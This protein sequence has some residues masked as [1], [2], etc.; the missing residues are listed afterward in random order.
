MKVFW[1]GVL[2]VFTFYSY[3]TYLEYQRRVKH[4]VE[5][6]SPS[7]YS[8]LNKDL[9]TVTIKPEG[10]SKLVNDSLS[11]INN[12]KYSYI[13]ETFSIDS[14]E[15]L[16]NQ[17]LSCIPESFGYSVERGKEV[18]QEYWYPKC[19]EKTKQQGTY[20]HI[21]RDSNQVTM[22]CPNKEQG[23]L[24]LGPLD[25]RKIVKSE[26]AFNDWKIKEYKNP[27]PADKVEFALGKCGEG[28]FFQASMQ[29][30]FNRSSYLKA[31]AKM[32]SKPKLIYFLTMDSMSRRHSYRKIPRVIDFLNSLNSNKSSGFSVFDFKIHNILGPDSISNQVPIFGGLEN[33]VRDFSGKQEIDRLG[34]N[35]IWSKLREKGFVSLLGLENCDSYF[36]GALGRSPDVDYSVGPFYCA[37][38]KYSNLGFDKRFEKVQRCLGGYQTHF[39]ILNYTKTV[40]EMNEGV[41]L[42]LYNHLNAAH[43]SSG[44]HAATLNDDLTEF[45]QDFLERF[46]KKYDI[47]IFL[48]ADHGMRY[49]NWFKDTDAYQENKLPTLFIIASDSLLSSY[50]VSYHALT[51]NSERLTSKLDLRQ[52]TLYLAG[53]DEPSEHSINLLTSIIPKSRVCE[54][55]RIS[56]WDCACINM[57][58]L[59]SPDP[60]ATVIINQLMTYAEKIINKESYSWPLYPLGR[61]CKRVVLDSVVRVLHV[62]ISNVNE[63]FKIEFGSSTKKGLIFQVNFLLASDGRATRRLGYLTESLVFNARVKVKILSISRVDAFAGECEIKARNLGIKPEYCI[64]VD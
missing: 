13:P 7:R 53:I 10:K 50:N 29:P 63:F 48:N 26:E 58:E 42:W 35:S 1:L 31:K 17:G 27:L 61:H 21:D 12:L 23:Q 60:S 39:Y 16:R 8:R 22:N 18:F 56:A 43:E 37:V 40:V 19:S 30:I 41:N 36:P 33:F 2:A 47:W 15:K 11:P 34:N 64:C 14:V 59:K 32:T 45:L 52:T 44:L 6:V 25:S 24:L 62:S 49:G 51:V 38:Q 3:D 4:F 20:L 9:V 46:K 28:P 5:F 55:L 57:K 54:D